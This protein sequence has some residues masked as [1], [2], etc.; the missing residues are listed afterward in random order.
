MILLQKWGAL[1]SFFSGCKQSSP[2]NARHINNKQVYY[3]IFSTKGVTESQRY[4]DPYDSQNPGVRSGSMSGLLAPGKG[5]GV[6]LRRTGS[7]HGWKTGVFSSWPRPRASPLQKEGFTPSWDPVATQR[8]LEVSP[9]TLGFHDPSWRYNI[10]QIGWNQ[11]LISCLCFKG[12]FHVVEKPALGSRKPKKIDFRCTL[13]FLVA[14]FCRDKLLA[15]GSG[16]WR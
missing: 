10:F 2:T 12:K 5:L 1:G 4:T 6:E 11:Q 8:F 7:F 16:R 15:G 14:S 9:R 13:D 3:Q